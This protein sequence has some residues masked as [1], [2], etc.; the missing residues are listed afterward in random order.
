MNIL[1]DLR[2]FGGGE[3]EVRHD[4]VGYCRC[5]DSSH[6]PSD[7]PPLELNDANPAAIEPLESSAVA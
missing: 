1:I 3:N 2:A 7:R 6:F 4:R 5:N